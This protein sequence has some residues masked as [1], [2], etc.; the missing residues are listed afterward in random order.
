MNSRHSLNSEEQDSAD[1][2][3]RSLLT[4]GIC[5][6]LGVTLIKTTIAHA[7]S[8]AD[9]DDLSSAVLSMR[10]SAGY[11]DSYADDKK[12]CRHCAFFKATEGECGACNALGGPVN[13]GGHCTSWSARPQST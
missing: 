8:C 13:A 3:R 11:T 12:T 9:P 7:A 2:G 5:L 6:S 4:K 1:L 10:Q